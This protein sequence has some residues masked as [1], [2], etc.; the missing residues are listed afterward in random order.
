MDGNINWRYFPYE[1]PDSGEGIVLYF[2]FYSK[3]RN[4]AAFEEIAK[5]LKE[6]QVEWLIQRGSYWFLDFDK[7]RD[8]HPYLTVDFPWA[9]GVHR[10]EP[11][12]NTEPSEKDGTLKT[13]VQ[14]FITEADVMSNQD[15]IFL[16][17][18]GVDKPL[19]R[20]FK[21]TLSIIGLRP[22][23][24][25]DAMPA[26]TSLERGLLK[27]FRESCA[28]VFFI[29]HSFQDEGYLGSEVEYAIAQK[30]EKGDRFAII[31]LLFS[32]PA[33]GSPTVPE[34]LQPFVWKKPTD[35]L[36]ALREILR[37]LPLELNPSW[38]A[39]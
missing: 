14:F 3:K 8:S 6:N 23:L 20:S 17:H 22:W 34:L 35:H 2:P 28:A 5:S 7:L 29:T 10:L 19:A 25:E 1:I 33:S 38:K 16:S 36:E 18:K 11:E 9:N 26:G 13:K 21:E 31:T 12:V 24:D 37:A 15:R 30:R 4:Q 39:G 32:D 27:G